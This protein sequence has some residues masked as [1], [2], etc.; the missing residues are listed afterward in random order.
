M[1]SKAAPIVSPEQPLAGPGRMPVQQQP[2][3]C[4]DSRCMSASLLGTGMGATDPMLM[5]MVQHLALQMMIRDQTWP[6]GAAPGMLSS[7]QHT[8]LAQPP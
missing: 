5:M 1:A 3:A 7:T 6:M 8:S 2:A 4:A